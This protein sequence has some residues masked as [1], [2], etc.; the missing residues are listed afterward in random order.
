[1][2]DDA[3]ADAP[4][5]FLGREWSPGILSLIITPTLDGV[6]PAFKGHIPALL[7]RLRT[8]EHPHKFE[9][10]IILGDIGRDAEAAIP[11][12]LS[13]LKAPVTGGAIDIHRAAA[14]A[15][16]KIG[17]Q[18]ATVV[19]VLAETLQ[20][21]RMGLRGT[22]IDALGNFGPGAQSAIPSLLPLLDGD[23]LFYGGTV[24]RAL[25]KIDPQRFAAKKVP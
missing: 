12:L 18:P 19:P 11:D 2:L 25:A 4:A 10:A 5:P 22:A 3:G 21:E 13:L 9:I 15:L 16:G 17:K 24:A 7:R 8:E 14:Y 6:A 20:N 1:M 23:E